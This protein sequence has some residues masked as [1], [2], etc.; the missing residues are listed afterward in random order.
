[1]KSIK[2]INKSLIVYPEHKIYSVYK[3]IKKSGFRTLAVINEYGKLLGTI[4]DGDIRRFLLRGGKINNKIKNVYNS[5]PKVYYD[6]SYNINNIKKQVIKYQYGIVPIIDKK[7]NIIKIFT[8][9]DIFKNEIKKR[10]K[11]LD[12]DV[13]I[14]AG[15]EGTRLK[16]YTNILPNPLVPLKERP[17]ID[18]IISSFAQNGLKK[19]HITIN[20]KSK[21]IKS[22]FQ[23]RNQ[24]YKISLHE[25]KNPLGTVGA[26]RTFTK[27]LSNNF[28]LTNC[29]TVFKMN[30]HNIYEF[31]KK[32]KFM[33]TMA[34]SAKDL[35]FPYGSCKIDENNNLVAMEEKP[36]LK[37]FANTGL[38]I[39]NKDI[40]RLI[41]KNRYFDITDLISACRK[42]KFKVGAFIIKNKEWLDVGHVKDF[43]KAIEEI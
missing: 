35:N 25:E 27:K 39:L 36:K 43:N 3:K 28:I 24:N 5:K 21:I 13:V 15:G 17:I 8:W 19:F 40:T 33:L 1:M 22:F 9:D 2:N 37:L 16:P 29:D 14:M 42:N 23:E 34:V 26:V 32:N 20:Y 12:L 18:Y 10:N 11:P 4:S 31:H 7:R 6:N 38:Y 41:P 30:F